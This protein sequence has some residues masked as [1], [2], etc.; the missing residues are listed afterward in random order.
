MIGRK[1]SWPGRAATVVGIVLLFFQDLAPARA[2]GLN[3]AQM[4]VDAIK[5]LE[6]RLTDAGCYKG[7]IDGSAGVALDDAIKACPDQRPFLRIE[8]GMHTLPIS[9]IG[10]DAACRLL[11]TASD[12]KTVRLWSLPEGKTSAGLSATDWRGRRRQGLRDS[13]FAGWAVACRWRMGRRLWRDGK[14]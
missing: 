11:A 13:A 3:P 4:G 7:A 6:Q 5:A 8:I 10:V 14:V 9:S 1:A 12:D 2:W